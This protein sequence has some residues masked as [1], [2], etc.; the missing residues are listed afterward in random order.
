LFYSGKIKVVIP[1][2]FAPIVFYFTPPIG[3]T[4]PERVIYPVIAIYLII[5]LF[6]ARE[7]KVQVIATPAEGPS[8]PI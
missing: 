1:Y 6:K 7:T 2:L 5:G 3:E 8:L 4:L